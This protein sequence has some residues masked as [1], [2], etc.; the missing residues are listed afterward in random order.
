MTGDRS[1]L[2]DF[3]WQGTEAKTVILADGERKQVCGVGTSVITTAAGDRVLVQGVCLVPGLQFNLLS[4]AQMIRKGATI[5]LDSRGC[6]ISKDGVNV[7]G[8]MSGGLFLVPRGQ[9]G[10]DQPGAALYSSAGVE[11]AELVHRRMA[12]VSFEALA[13]MAANKAVKGLGITAGQF[14]RHQSD[15]CASCIKG[16]LAQAPF[17]RSSSYSRP[18]ELVHSDICGPLSPASVGGSRYMISLVDDNTGYAELGFLRHKSEG[19]KWVTETMLRW[20]RGTKSLIVKFR[21]DQGAE[22]LSGEFRAFL[23]QRGIAQECSATYTPQQNG[24]AERLNR[25]VVERVRSMLADSQQDKRF[26]AEA[27]NT[28]AYLRNRTAQRQQQRTPFEL[29][30]G[31]TPSIRHLRVWGSQAFV[32]V[33]PAVRKSKLDAVCWEGY[34]MGYS[35]GIKGYKVWLPSLGRFVTSRDVVFDESLPQQEPASS[36]GEQPSMGQEEEPWRR[37]TE[38]QQPAGQQPGVQP[39]AGQQPGV[40]PPAGQQPGVQPGGQQQGGQ[41][42]GGQPPGGQQ[43]GGQQPGAGPPPPRY[44]QRVRNPPSQ[45]WAAAAVGE[46]PKG[47]DLPDVP[48]TVEEAR[49]GP[50]AAQWEAAMQEEMMNFAENQVYS[51]QQ[52]PAGVAPVAC[53][54]V[55]ALKTDQE[56]RLERFK[57]RLVAKG[58]TQRQGVDYEEVFAPVGK[59][60]TLRAF[61]AVGAARDL[62][63]HQLDV[64]AAFLNGALEEEIYM[65]QPPGFEQG[66]PRMV[67]RLHKAVYGLKQASRAWYTTLSTQLGELGFKVSAADAGLFII[68]S[69]GGDVLLCV[70]VDDMLVAG[71]GKQLSLVKQGLGKVFK[72]KDKGEVRFHLGMEVTRDR[73]ARS[74]RLTQTKYATE[75]VGRFGME[76]ART[77]A[78]P[79]GVASSLTKGGGTPLDPATSRYAE[80][81]GGL[82]YLSTCT[83][84]DISYAVGVL[85]RFMGAPTKEHWTAALTVLRY[86]GG[87]LGM[88]LQ[89]GGVPS[90]SIVGF[91]DADYAGDL[92]SRRSTTGFVF[93]LNGAAVSWRSKCQPTV[94]TSTSEAEYMAAAAAIKE[95]LWL[96]Q[97]L[98]ELGVSAA[99]AVQIGVDNQGAIKL[100]NGSAAVR[101]KHIDVMHHFA[102][103][104]VAR[105]EVALQYVPTI[106]MIA[107]FLT[108]PLSREKFEQFRKDAGVC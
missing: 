74:L 59:Q 42:P 35:T 83:R 5:S 50:C 92:D 9:S 76:Q 30:W 21:S 56:G 104:R 86:V 45:W 13:R 61:V 79:M 33:P 57:A 88:G 47:Q 90:L 1:I 49:A 19:V 24:V 63:I 101:S 26:W 64:T 68:S 81:V 20:E 28:A 102:R 40:Q 72:L 8:E 12:H 11:S 4:A 10:G 84:P 58:F 53:R 31:K 73:A 44:P 94:A 95:A 55:F 38:E 66:G 15:P 3:F 103:E 27:A 46:K 16:K 69:D 100:L 77:V 22:Y 75:L 106:N 93:K 67:W 41:Q 71:A 87:T 51:V 17:A 7:M 29:F 82:L 34:M 18:L 32:R 91:A 6:V 2:Q 52:A 65:Q 108:K 85:S 96:K 54:W 14:R 48:A 105:G 39:P 89:F 97:L 43:Q 60:S 80:L 25:S 78:V 23:R 107:D 37:A 98:P 36:G 70:H 99:S 62:D